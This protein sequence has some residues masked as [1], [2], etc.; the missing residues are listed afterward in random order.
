ME[1]IKELEEEKERLIQELRDAKWGIVECVR[2]R[3]AI[4]AV[5]AELDRLYQE[6]P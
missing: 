2:I 5:Q 6:L 3:R 4:A 1:K